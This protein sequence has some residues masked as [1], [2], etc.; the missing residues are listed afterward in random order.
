MTRPT[1]PET[2]SPV[3]GLAAW[4][5]RSS[6]PWF[7]KLRSRRMRE[8]VSVRRMPATELSPGSGD[9]Q[10]HRLHAQRLRSSR[11]T[12]AGDGAARLLGAELRFRSRTIEHDTKFDAVADQERFIVV[13]PN[14]KLDPRAVRFHTA[15]NSGMEAHGNHEARAKWRTWPRSSRKCRKVQG[16]PQPHPHPG[17]FLRR[18]DD[19]GGHG[20][21]PRNL[22]LRLADG[23][24]ALQ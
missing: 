1:I 17:N 16:G 7:A 23:G 15:G 20:G 13:Y 18:G 21:L 2:P 11:D 24:Y 4:P 10:V 3:R 22:R 12:A 6:P 19:R 9:A 5:S 14:H 8:N